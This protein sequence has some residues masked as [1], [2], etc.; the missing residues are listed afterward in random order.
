ME[1]IAVITLWTILLL[2]GIVCI[3]AGL[4]LLFALKSFS[5]FD[6]NFTQK[7]FTPPSDSGSK[8]YTFA[9]NIIFT[10]GHIAGIGFLA[11]GIYFLYYFVSLIIA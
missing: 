6:N 10:R 8:Y 2:S 11:L 9:H 1:N 4:F 5:D 7:Y 3:I